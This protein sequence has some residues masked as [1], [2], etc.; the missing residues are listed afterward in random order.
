MDLEK[1]FESG[2]KAQLH[3]VNGEEVW[4]EYGGPHMMSLAKEFGPQVLSLPS[5][6]FILSPRWQEL[7]YLQQS[8]A[9]GSWPFMEIRLGTNAVVVPFEVTDQDILEHLVMVFPVQFLTEKVAAGVL[10]F[11]AKTREES[12]LANFQFFS[13]SV[14]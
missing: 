8:L 11:I 5:N 3:A 13:K 4:V 10:V 12:G 9:E 7:L 6:W 2:P 1:L 14:H